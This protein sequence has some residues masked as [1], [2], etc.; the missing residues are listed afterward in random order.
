[1]EAAVTDAL[2]LGC[3]DAGAIAV[4]VR[5]Q[6]ADE[7]APAPPLTDLGS[8]SVYERPAGDVAHYNALLSPLGMPA[9]H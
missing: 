9:V 2:R 8:L 6:I 4:L 3:C 5:H 7:E 1:V